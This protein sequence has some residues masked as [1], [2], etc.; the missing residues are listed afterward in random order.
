MSKFNVTISKPRYEYYTYMVDAADE[1]DAMTK[2]GDMLV[3]GDITDADLS[4]CCD[5]PQYRIVDDPDAYEIVC[6]IEYI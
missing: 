1:S 2:V 4:F 5:E 3:N 6:A